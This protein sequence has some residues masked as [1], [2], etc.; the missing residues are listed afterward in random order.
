MEKKNLEYPAM[1]RKQPQKSA[2][3][4]H[5]DEPPRGLQNDYCFQKGKGVG[6][7][8]EKSGP[9]ELPMDHLIEQLS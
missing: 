3:Q 9:R 4:S 8:V 7:A 1:I 5:S 2:S 6:G